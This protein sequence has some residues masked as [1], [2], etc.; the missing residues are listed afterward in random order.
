MCT[1]TLSVVSSQFAIVTLKLR[2]DCVAESTSLFYQYANL[3]HPQD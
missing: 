3:F 1:Q 2:R